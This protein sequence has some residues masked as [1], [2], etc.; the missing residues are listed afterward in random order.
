M[1]GSYSGNVNL[2]DTGYDAENNLLPDEI[3]APFGLSVFSVGQQI[4][5]INAGPNSGNYY[6]RSVT[7]TVM[8]LKDETGAAVTWITPAN[9][10]NVKINIFKIR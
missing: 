5:L 10:V 7:D 9:A 3:H 8:T 6:V 1:V 2:I 4:T